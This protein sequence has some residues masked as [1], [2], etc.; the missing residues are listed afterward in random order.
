MDTRPETP[1][2]GISSMGSSS[3]CSDGDTVLSVTDGG[4][5]FASSRL[6]DLG[7]GGLGLVGDCGTG[8]DTRGGSGVP[9][10]F[11]S[12]SRSGRLG[13]SVDVEVD[14]VAVLGG[15]D[16]GGCASCRRGVAVV[17]SCSSSSSGSV[18][19]SAQRYSLGRS[20]G[21]G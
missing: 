11:V 14:V 12:C 10:D 7:T 16:A 9:F 4:V 20:P 6:S 17:E 13:G 2:G 15:S 19:I 18:C 5:A 3:S 1:S 8:C 21:V